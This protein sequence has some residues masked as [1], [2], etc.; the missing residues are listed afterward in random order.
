MK[1]LRQ[2]RNVR[3]SLE[4]D[5]N[6]SLPLASF[7]V[8]A[9]VSNP[10]CVVRPSSPGSCWERSWDVVRNL[11]DGLILLLK[12]RSVGRRWEIG[13]DMFKHSVEAFS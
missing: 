5:S 12:V 11:L 10:K 9:T 13:R 1:R 6:I 4:R 2:L 3:T 7:C 8:S